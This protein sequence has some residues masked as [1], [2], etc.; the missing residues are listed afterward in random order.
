MHFITQIEPQAEP[1]FTSRDLM[2]ISTAL[3]EFRKEFETRAGLE[4]SKLELYRVHKVVHNTMNAR[5]LLT[6]PIVVYT[7]PLEAQA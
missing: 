3:Q 7:H 1:E 4:M 2:T 6:L 5:G